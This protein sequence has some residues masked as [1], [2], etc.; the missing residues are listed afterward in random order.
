MTPHIKGEEK[1]SSQSD[2]RSKHDTETA[3][4]TKSATL[5]RSLLVL[6]ARGYSVDTQQGRASERPNEGVFTKANE[7]L[8]NCQNKVKGA[9]EC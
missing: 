5:V 7:L 4:E 2:S 8:V 1:Y 9:R 3:N 6:R